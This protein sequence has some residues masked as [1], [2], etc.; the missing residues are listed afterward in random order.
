[1]Y[2]QISAQLPESSPYRPRLHTDKLFP[3]PDSAISF[4]GPLLQAMQFV[5]KTQLL[6]SE[7]WTLF[8]RQFTPGTDDADHGWRC[9]YWGKSM[10][11]GCMVY[12]C[13]HDETLYAQLT[14]AVRQM[15]AMQAPDGRISSYSLAEEFRGWDLWGRK[16]VLLGME[17]YL[18]ICRDKSLCQAVLTAMCAHADYIIAHIGSAASGKIEINTATDHWGGLNSS[19]ILEPMMLLYN[20][21]GQARY[22]EF[23]KYIVSR[24]GCMQA[25][26]FE[27]AYEGRLYPYE[28]PV[29][30]AYEMMSCFE[31]LL[32]YYRVTGIEKWRVAV[33][34]FARLVMR[35]D[36]TLI[37]CAGCTHELFD[38]AA[39]RQFL[40]SASG[41][42]QETCV[43]VTWMKLCYQLLCLTGDACFA[44][45]I[46]RSLYNALFGAINTERC[47]LVRNP[48]TGEIFDAGKTTHGNGLPF[49]SYSPL[50]CGTRGRGTGGLMHMHDGTL[51]GCCAAIG[52]AGL[53][54]GGQCAVM[55]RADGVAVNQYLPGRF[56]LCP[57]VTLHMDTKYPVDGTLTLRVETQ[58]PKPFALDLR[59]PEWSTSSSVLINGQAVDGVSSG[60][61]LRLARLWNNGD[62]V[63]LQLDMRVTI[64]TP[65]DFGVHEPQPSFL[66]FQRGPLVLARDARLGQDV[67]RPVPLHTI[68]DAQPDHEVAFAHLYACRLT[69]AGESLRLVDYA[70]AGKTW[71]EASRM[72][73]WLA[74]AHSDSE[75]TPSI[76]YDKFS[77]PA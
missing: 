30:K 9:E 10:R 64:R 69:S 68:Y 76:E 65:A 43:T 27:L 63:T 1:M 54:I 13:T 16:Y 66:A 33:E 18:Q 50:L 24:G 14:A 48:E 41:I 37:G 5:T 70:S 56:S 17:H 22:L 75:P 51:Y 8:V 52:A 62:T 21:T 47:T 58:T 46:E 71:D 60:G 32:E 61:Y 31:G 35:S 4:E 7:L 59:I 42:L 12:A 19:S 25:N 49:D 28:Y 3:L 73:A 77:Y 74:V 34:N 15:L 53:A 20:R 44:A 36:I 38:H 11:G 67:D 26:L 6:D 23:A 2:R 29:T 39:A 72:A 57:S 40:S 45:Q 55:L